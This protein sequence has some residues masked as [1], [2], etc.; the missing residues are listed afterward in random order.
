VL[1]GNASKAG[2]YPWVV[3]N[4]TGYGPLSN[5]GKALSPNAKKKM[6]T[7]LLVA[8]VSTARILCLLRCISYL[9]S[10]SDLI[11]CNERILIKSLKI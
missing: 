5:S 4:P 7:Y 2:M 1:S 3:S 6:I 9:F 8:E 10:S 11:I